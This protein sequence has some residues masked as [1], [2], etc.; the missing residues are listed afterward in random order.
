MTNLG[1]Q[2]F[3]FCNYFLHFV[4]LGGPDEFLFHRTNIISGNIDFNP[5]EEFG[6]ALPLSQ[7]V[8]FGQEMKVIFTEPI[9]CELPLTFDIEMTVEETRNDPEIV[10]KKEDLLL[11]CE[12]RVLKIQVDYTRINPRILNGRDFVVEVGRI[13]GESASYIADRNGNPID[14]QTKGN[15]RFAKQFVDANLR[16]ALTEF[17]FTK[18]NES[19]DCIQKNEFDHTNDLNMELGHL[20]GMDNQ[21]RLR[22]SDVSCNQSKSSISAKVEILPSNDGRKLL[23]GSK[24]TEEDTSTDLMVKLSDS[25]L[26]H[27]GQFRR[28]QDTNKTPKYVI[29]HLR[30]IPDEEDVKKYSATEAEKKEEQQILSSLIGNEFGQ[31]S[32]VAFAGNINL[33]K[34]MTPENEKIDKLEN[35]EKILFEERNEIEEERK[36]LRKEKEEDLTNLVR[37]F[38]NKRSGFDLKEVFVMQVV[39]LFIGC[40]LGAVSIFLWRGN[41]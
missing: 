28:L 12:N 40:I 31:P 32:L 15:I 18:R 19:V 23:K 34:Q 1:E 25:L 9:D 5:P 21:D 36:R 14:H 24:A 38:E 30:I 4:I 20:V 11:I 35:L 8:F 29:S 41:K 10:L 16:R 22:V 26:H 37:E 27:E 39:F 7:R 17:H 6:Y 3:H 33:K 2:L 13:G